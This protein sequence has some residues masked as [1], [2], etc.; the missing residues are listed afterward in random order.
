MSD[1]EDSYY[2]F[3]RLPLQK[4]PHQEEIN[5]HTDGKHRYWS[6]WFGHAYLDEKP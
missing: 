5:R 3:H 4:E 1:F 2:S 6:K